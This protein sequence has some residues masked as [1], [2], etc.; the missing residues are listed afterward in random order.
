MSTTPTNLPVPSEKPQDLKF[1]AGKIDEFVTSMAKQYI[2]RFGHAHYTIEGLRWVAQQ[3]ISAFGYITLKSFQLGAPLPNNELTLPNQVLQDESDGEYYRW[4]GVFP[5]QVPAG[6]TPQSTGG[7]GVGA[8][9]SVG[10]APL[11]G[12]L[13][14]E[15]ILY[16]TPQ[17]FDAI[18]DGI[19]DDTIPL[20]NAMD[21]CQ[22]NNIKLVIPSGRYRITKPLLYRNQ[23]FYNYEIEGQGGAAVIIMDSLAKTGITAPDVNGI[24]VNVNAAIVVLTDTN[25]SKYCRI[26]G[27]RFESPVHADY[28]IYVTVT[29]NSLITYCFFTGFKFGVYDKGSWVQRIERCIARNIVDTGF[30][31]ETGTS[32]YIKECYADM[33]ER[34]YYL[35][36]GYSAIINCACDKTTRWSYFLQGGPTGADLAVYYIKGCGSENSGS[37]SVFHCEGLVC[38]SIEDHYAYNDATQQTPTPAALLS[39]GSA[40]AYSQITMKNVRTV[41][42]DTLIADSANHVYFDLTSVTCRSDMSKK[43]YLGSNS[44]VLERTYD[45]ERFI[46]SNDQVGIGFAESDIVDGWTDLTLSGL[47]NGQFII[48]KSATVTRIGGS[49]AGVTITLPFN[50][51]IDYTVCVSVL[52]DLA[53]LE[54]YAPTHVVTSKATNSFVVGIV[55]SKNINTWTSFDIDITITGLKE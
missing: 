35:G 46:T 1:N 7:K 34:G 29:E 24:D 8:W 53:G 30:F 25:Q 9:L 27:I 42:V 4:D 44:R 28:A 13:F 51:R 15:Y 40:S 52:A 45:G 5:K 32:T 18:G 10:D 12:E 37:D 17:A 6:S 31:I 26:S 38:A 47:R 43:Y 21:Y 3:A 22:I 14:S 41:G 48:R 50:M 36:G 23:G 11:R 54:T 16:K 55:S 2:D 33:M 19:A 20:Q 39:T 49:S